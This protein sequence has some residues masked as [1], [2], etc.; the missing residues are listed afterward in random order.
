MG[1]VNV[2]VEVKLERHWRARPEGA[3]KASSVLSTRYLHVGSAV[4]THTQCNGTHCNRATDEEEK[5]RG[6]VE[7]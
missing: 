5:K 2:V 4:I 1:F 3:V 6:P 7:Q